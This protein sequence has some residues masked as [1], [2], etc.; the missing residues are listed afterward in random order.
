MTKEE[1]I[2]TTPKLAIMPET[3]FVGSGEDEDEKYIEGSGSPSSLAYSGDNDDSDNEYS[4]DDGEDGGSGDGKYETIS[5]SSRIP[6]KRRTKEIIVTKEGDQKQK[7]QQQKPDEPDI[8]PTASNV[9][10]RPEHVFYAT[11]PTLHVPAQSNK[12]ASAVQKLLADFPNEKVG[13]DLSI[14]DKK[15]EA[16]QIK[17]KTHISSIVETWNRAQ[18]KYKRLSQKDKRKAQKFLLSKQFY[19]SKKAFP[20]ST[21]P[22][23]RAH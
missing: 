5:L 14:Y 19:N 11:F 13:C 22:S 10:T 9:L 23:R 6:K 3:T 15:E 21:E 18:E 16:L 8:K 17:Y 2:F 12:L 1:E 4:G 7:A 20:K